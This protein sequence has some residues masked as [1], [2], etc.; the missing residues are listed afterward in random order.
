MRKNDIKFNAIKFVDIW[1]KCWVSK[2]RAV[3]EKTVGFEM[4]WNRHYLNGDKVKKE[5][6]SKDLN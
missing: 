1:E 5:H 4:G 2:R 6:I 3:I